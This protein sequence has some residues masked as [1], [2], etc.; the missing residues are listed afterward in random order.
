MPRYRGVVID[1]QPYSKPTARRHNALGSANV[2]LLGHNTFRRMK[3]RSGVPLTVGDVIEFDDIGDIGH[4]VMKMDK[5]R[6]R[7]LLYK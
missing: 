3:V 4:N 6:S 1:Y 5:R 2:R 7:T